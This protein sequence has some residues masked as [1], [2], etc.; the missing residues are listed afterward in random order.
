MHTKHVY[1]ASMRSSLAARKYVSKNT[2]SRGCSSHGICVK[3]LLYSLKSPELNTSDTVS[4]TSIIDLLNLNGPLY[5]LL[6]DSLLRFSDRAKMLPPGSSA[7]GTPFTLRKARLEM[8]R[9]QPQQAT[10][11]FRNYA[12]CNGY[13]DD[14]THL[15]KFADALFCTSQIAIAHH[16]CPGGTGLGRT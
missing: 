14:M 11:V 2:H 15:A 8:Q 9:F 5:D 13:L 12:S 4:G 1:C 7:I 6:L 3:P 10:S 16:M